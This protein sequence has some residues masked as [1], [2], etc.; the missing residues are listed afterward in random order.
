MKRMLTALLASA[1][2]VPVMANAQTTRYD[3]PRYD[4]Y[5]T[6]TTERSSGPGSSVA[7]MGDVGWQRYSREVSDQINSGVGY[8]LKVDL[9]PQR[10]F[11]FELFYAGAVNGMDD[12]FSTD[13]NIVTNQVGGNLRLNLVPPTTRA[14]IR[15]FVFGGASYYNIATNNFTPGIRGGNLFAIPAGLGIEADISERFL[16]GARFTYNFLFRE[17]DGFS[18]RNA[19]SW[20][21]GANI[22]ARLGNL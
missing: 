7:I 14:L 5:G 6:T 13:G 3:D 4:D 22:G 10:N 21:L 1:L 18:G 12:R 19:D 9:S 17:Q 16:V 8:G 11:G 15:P 2:F 20:L